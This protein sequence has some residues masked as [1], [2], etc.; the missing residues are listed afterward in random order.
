MAD[1]A[2][3]KRS[4]EDMMDEMVCKCAACEKEI[5]AVHFSKSQKAKGAKRRCHDCVQA[6]N[7]IKNVNSNN[8]DT[9]ATNKL[10]HKKQ[11]P[12]PLCCKMCQKSKKSS[13]YPKDHSDSPDGPTCVDCILD[14]VPRTCMDCGHAKPK[15]QYSERQ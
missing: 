8:N 12:A 6:N 10:I 7:P 2:A 1:Q 11:R 4:H 14:S 3:N 15:D 9:T 5:S 13:A